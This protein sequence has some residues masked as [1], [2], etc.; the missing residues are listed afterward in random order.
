V[1]GFHT[2]H[3]TEWGPPKA[4]RVVICAHGYSGNARDFDYLARALA[5][6]ARVICIDVAGRGESDWL[7]S[8]LAYNFGTFLADINSLIAHLGV[9][10]VEWV[11]TSMGGLLGM[12]LASQPGNRVRRLVMN[13]IGAFVPVDAL[14]AISRNLQAPAHFASLEEVEA[15]MRH[16]HREWGDLTAEQWRHFTIH[17]ARP[18]GDGWRLHFDPKITRIVRPLPL[19]PGVFFWDA[20]YRVRCPV[21][22]LRGE[23]SE[24]FPVSV[25]DTMLQV[26]PLA[27]LVEIPGCGHAP[28]LMSESQIAIVRN[29]LRPRADKA[30]W[31]RQSSSSRDSSR[32]PTRSSTRSRTSG[33]S[34]AAP[35]PT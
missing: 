19:S 11:G 14:Q 7:G 29:F 22:L 16:T 12:L 10:E 17:G 3:Y 31:S 27:E 2:L 35:S 18:D 13:D 28:A 25:A 15:H 6:D 21:L 33:S 32:T 1:S 30:Q 26:K 23:R 4:S 9:K 20:W 34:P 8:H 5:K 24:I